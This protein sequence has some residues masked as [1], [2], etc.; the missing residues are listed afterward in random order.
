M[1]DKLVAQIAD[2]YRQLAERANYR[3]G[4]PSDGHGTI[5]VPVEELDLDREAHEYAVRW[6]AEERDGRFLIG[7]P[8]YSG[9]PLMVYLVEAARATCA[10]N[11]VLAQELVTMAQAELDRLPKHGRFTF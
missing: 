11:Y 8:D 10:V 4:A 7:C 5:T 6:L 1:S 3:P 9:G 2:A